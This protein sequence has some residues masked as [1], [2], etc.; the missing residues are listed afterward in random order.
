[1]APWLVV[2]LWFTIPLVYSTTLKKENHSIISG[3]FRVEVSSNKAE[4]VSMRPNS[5]GRIFEGRSLWP[6]VD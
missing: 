4:M 2:F 3:I 5:F 1:M 6:E